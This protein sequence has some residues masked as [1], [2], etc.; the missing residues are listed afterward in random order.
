MLSMH[1]LFSIIGSFLVVIT[2]PLV[3]ELLLVTIASLLPR[4]D[5]QSVIGHGTHRLAVVIP[6]HNEETSISRCVESLR[7]SA[8]HSVKVYV[9]AHNCTDL[10]AQLAKS[11]GAEVLVYDDPEAIGKGHVLRFGFQH[12]IQCG[13]DA[14][15]VVDADSVVSVNLL[16]AVQSAFS[17]GVEAVQCRYEMKGAKGQVKTELISL[18]LRGFN[19]IRPL[20]RQRI[21]LSAGILGNGFALSANVLKDVPYDAL[22]VVEDLEYHLHLVLAGKRVHFL[23]EAVVSSELPTSTKGETVQHS[24]WEGGRLRVAHTWLPKLLKELLRGKLTVLEPLLDLAGLPIAF[25]MMALLSAACLPLSWVRLYV[26]LA[27]TV[28]L[29][30][31]L[32]AISAG[33]RRLH[34][35]RVLLLVPFYLLWKLRLIPSVLRASSAKAAW[36]RTDRKAEDRIAA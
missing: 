31:V 13:A 10:T 5:T 21:G 18:A 30:H 25:G 23:D 1:I 15:L 19:F 17:Q 11:A 7:V 34:A 26:V 4:G 28:L 24:R 32:R 27:M 2:A 36:I 22:S 12:S 9:V 35:L 16:P 14:V 8:D 6:A 29:A 33:P 3:V 20:G